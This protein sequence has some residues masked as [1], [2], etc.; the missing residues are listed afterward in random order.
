[1]DKYKNKSS[2]KAKIALG[3]AIFVMSIFFIV[4]TMVF[5]EEIPS[6]P[7]TRGIEYGCFLLFIPI[8]GVFAKEFLKRGKED[9]KQGIYLKKL[10][11]V[12]IE[13]SHNH[14]FYEGD[15]TNGAKALVKEVTNSIDA[16]RCSIWLYNEDKTSILCEQ[17]Y[18]KAEDTFYQNIELFEKDFGGYFEHLTI[19]PIIVANDAET[20]PATKCFTESYLKP[21]GIKSMLDVPIVYKGKVIGVICIENLSL[22]EWQKVEVDFAQM[23]SSLYSFAYSVRESNIVSNE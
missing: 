6:T 8:F 9:A 5:L 11:N 17:L 13:Q 3:L 21:L 10:N 23:L 20:H 4:K 16:D 14:L 22:R 19:D 15:V 2:I 18:V 1:M 7:M 12:L